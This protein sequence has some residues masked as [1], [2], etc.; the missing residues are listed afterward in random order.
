MRFS[1][2]AEFGIVIGYMFSLFL[3]VAV[4]FSV[5][6]LYQDQLSLQDENIRSISEGAIYKQLKSSFSLSDPYFKSGQVQFLLKN[7]ADISLEFKEEFY[8]CFDIFVN[9]DYISQENFFIAPQ[10]SLSGDYSIIEP[11]EVGILSIPNVN[12]GDNVKVVSC[13]GS[14]KIF[15]ITDENSY[16]YDDIFEKKASFLVSGS[17]FSDV[18]EYQIKLEINDSQ[19]SFSSFEENEVRVISPLNDYV[20]LDLNFNSYGQ[21]LE[22]N[23][24]NFLAVTL[25]GSTL[26]STDDPQEYKTG[27][28]LSSLDFDGDDFVR[29]FPFSMFENVEEFTLSFWVQLDQ[30]STGQLLFRNANIGEIELGNSLNS[31]VNQIRYYVNGGINRTSSNILSTSTWNH[32]LLRFNSGELC[33]FYNGQKDSC[34]NESV[35]TISGAL[36]QMDLGLGLDGKLDE[37]TFYSLALQD[38]EINLLMKDSLRYREL[39]FFIQDIDL[40]NSNIDLWVKV[41]YLTQAENHSIHI[42]YDVDDNENLQS[43][44]SIEDTFTYSSLRKIGYVLDQTQSNSQGLSIFSL[45]DDNQI[46][47]GDDLLTLNNKQAGSLL[48]GVLSFGDEV[49]TKGLVHITGDSAAGEMITP[50]SWAGREFYYRGF[51]NG[52]D[53]F[54]ILSPFGTANVDLRENG[55]IFNS[56]TIN[57]SGACII[58]DIGTTNN[59]AIESDIPILVTY[60][61]GGNQDP[62]VFFPATTEPLYGSPS[63]TL[64][65]AAGNLGASG[66]FVEESDGSSSVLS[67]GSYASANDGGNGPDGATNAFRLSSDFPIGAI[68]QADGDGSEA[69]V[70]A[71]IDEF[72]TYFGS[73]HDVSYISVVSNVQDANCSVYDS[74]DTLVG[75][76]PTGVGLN[77]LYKYDFG[78]G[79]DALYVAGP[80]TMVCSK[81][82][83]PYIENSE[84]DDDEQNILGYKQ[85]RQYV[86][87]EPQVHFLN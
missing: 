14:E 87:P 28:K 69:S 79:N 31:N 24:N 39:D 20:E 10:Y 56:T 66:G 48:S 27:V 45:Y 22:E 83:W 84:F 81:P 37:V 62:F 52:G 51:R 9:G 8:S 67:L 75:S 4:F 33:L 71:T 29:V 50:I 55:I 41:P 42:F 64:Y 25:G 6:Y 3:I 40:L 19:I 54:C 68:Q 57:S 63:Q 74:S 65:Y 7:T 85:M 11:Y 46:L 58:R 43:K 82:V 32:I 61:G 73:D 36:T 53:T 17:S 35:S 76:V 23:S 38:D 80:W 13:T 18:Y 86:Y 78:V 49:F 72:S 59:L 77:G 44:S 70:F 60:T 16:I 47:I 21:S 30:L 15:D 34:F 26:A 1:K 2:K 12:I 5:F